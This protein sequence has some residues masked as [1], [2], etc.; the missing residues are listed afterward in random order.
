MG[1]LAGP[2][3]LSAAGVIAAAGVLPLNTEGPSAIVDGTML[4]A[5]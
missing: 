2:A 4:V 1:A 3:L 5:V